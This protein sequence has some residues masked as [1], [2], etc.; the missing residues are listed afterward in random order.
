MISAESVTCFVRSS[1]FNFFLSM[2]NVHVYVFAYKMTIR[3]ITLQMTAK[4]RTFPLI[5]AYLVICAVMCCLFLKNM[6]LSRQRTS[7]NEC[8]FHSIG[9]QKSKV[10]R[11]SPHSLQKNDIFNFFQYWYA[12]IFESLVF[13]IESR[14][15]KKKFVSRSKQQSFC[16]TEH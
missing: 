7:S 15:S 3:Q 2:S 16:Q 12:S 13:L 1:T 6:I 4:G 8:L 10:K 5:I 9:K 14:D 11:N